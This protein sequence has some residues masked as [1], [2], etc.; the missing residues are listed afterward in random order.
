MGQ[1]LAVRYAYR[2]TSSDLLHS[3][4]LVRCVCDTV[5]LFTRQSADSKYLNK[6]TPTARH[7]RYRQKRIRLCACNENATPNCVI[8][9]A[10]FDQIRK[11]FFFTVH[12]ISLLCFFVFKKGWPTTANH[13]IIKFNIQFLSVLYHAISQSLFWTVSTRTYKFPQNILLCWKLAFLKFVP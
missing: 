12:S 4:R 2:W 8:H 1:S 6:I 13:P 10:I 7:I 5:L 11:N 3:L 9:I